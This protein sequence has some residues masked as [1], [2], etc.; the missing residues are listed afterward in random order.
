[1]RTPSFLLSLSILAYAACLPMLAFCVGDHCSDFTSWNVLKYGL[2]A[3]FAIPHPS[4]LIWLANPALLTAWILTA[5]A[6]VEPPDASN[7]TPG[8]KTAAVLVS[9]LALIIA[10]CFLLP[11]S[12]LNNEGGVLNAVTSRRAGYWLWL[13]S[14]LCAFASALWL[15]GDADKSARRQVPD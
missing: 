2:I 9:V 13:A 8:L 4:H 12:I 3:M 15:L 14:M 6:L 5:L 1:M 10:A 11:V 7:A